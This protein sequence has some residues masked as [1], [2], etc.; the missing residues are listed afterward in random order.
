M[1]EESQKPWAPLSPGEIALVFAAATFP[2]WIAG[3]HSIEHFVGRPLRRHGDIDVLVLA[4][5]R[6]RVRSF[7]AEWECWAADPPGTL[8][9]WVTGEELGV[10][11]HD[12]WCRAAAGGPWRF[13]LMLDEGDGDIWRSRRCPLVCK[14]VAELR[15]PRS[16]HPPFLAPEVQLFYKAKAPRPKDTLDFDACLPLLDERQRNWLR[17]AIAAAYGAENPWVRRFVTK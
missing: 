3:G 13:Q 9:P 16:S 12:V 7:L 10:G 1:S 4:K 17:G 11:V 2:W 15:A 8:R 5:D 14:P 6:A